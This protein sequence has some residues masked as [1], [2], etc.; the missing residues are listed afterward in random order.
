MEDTATG[1]CLENDIEVL[2]YQA[3]PNAVTE[4]GGNAQ[5]KMA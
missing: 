2:V 1:T 4:V 3:K 5:R